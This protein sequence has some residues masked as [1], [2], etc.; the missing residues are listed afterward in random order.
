M[1]NSAE[2]NALV[3]LAV[4]G[5]GARSDLARQ[6]AASGLGE[7]VALIDPDPVAIQRG[8]A[9]F[10]EELPAFAS[11]AEMLADDILIDAAFVLTPDHTH[12]EIAIEL[13]AAGLA[14]F[15]EKPLATTTSDADAVLQAAITAE[16][17]LYVGHNMRHMAVVRT[18]RDI[19]AR[20][21]IGEVKAVWC[22]HF[23]GNG[24][25]YYFK[26]WHAER[27]SSNGLLLQKGAHDIDIIHWLAGGYTKRVVG[28][29]GDTLYGALTDRR[30]NS[31]RTMSDWFSLDNWPPTE[32]RELNPVIDVEDLSMV[33]MRLDN[34]VY[35]S[36]EQCHYT[37]DYWRNYTVIGTKGRLENFGDTDGGVVR[38]WN[39]RRIY[40]PEG[41]LE[42][43]INGDEFGHDDAD[44]RTVTE[45]LR[46]VI[47]DTPTETSPIAG[48]NAVATAVAAT[49]SLRN[50]S[51]P[52]EIPSLA[53]ETIAYFDG[54]GSPST[55]A[56]TS[57]D[58]W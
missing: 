27:A 48:R 52:R 24:G 58:G 2:S 55:E 1:V 19:I 51:V 14:V 6:A 44:L 17:K 32:Q 11:A 20:G 53:E 26:D 50:S 35:A 12:A 38:V 25:D 4:I 43:P 5:C 34:G 28:M 29:G 33:L 47:D 7:I 36:Y 23:V 40:R 16:A 41:D 30:D 49:D 39:E 18:M 8:R 15:L 54:A 13:L 45:F 22:R 10:G 37:P 31:D 21:E 46:F 57:M 42:F 56:H 9:R 3:R